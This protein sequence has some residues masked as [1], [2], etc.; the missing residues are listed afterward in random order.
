MDTDPKNLWQRLQAGVDVAVAGNN[1]DVLLG[2]RD[3]FVRFFHD[4]I[5]KTVTV[6]I[7]PQAV[8]GPPP[9]GLPVSDED[10]LRSARASVAEMEATLADGHL[11]YVANEGGLHSLEVDGKIRYFVRNWTVVRC[12]AGEAWGASGSLQLPERLVEGLDSEQIPFAIPATRR[13]GGMIRSLTYGTETR[14]KAIAT[15]ALHA[16]SSVLYGFLEGR[17]LR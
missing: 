8:L 16:L 13:G 15:S 4:T 6:T 12:P 7:T 3:A 2:V 14:R 11:F 9:T 17:S 5:D 1:A 10:T